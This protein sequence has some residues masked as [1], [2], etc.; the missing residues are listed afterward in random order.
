MKKTLLFAGVLA[1]GI[2]FGQDISLLNSSEN[3]LVLSHELVPVSFETTDING[4]QAINF[5]ESHKITSME[6][7]APEIPFFT[8]S[9]HLP[10]KGKVILSVEHD[11]F[12]EIQN[13][14]VTPSKG[15][16]K[17]N[18][19]PS[20]VAFTFGE[21]YQTDAF[22]PG[23][24][25]E[26][27]EPY[28]F[29]TERGVTVQFNPYQY[30]PVTKTL[31]IYQNLRAVVSID[32]KQE[33]WNEIA[34]DQKATKKFNDYYSHH[35]INFS[36]P[37]Y[38]PVEEEGHMLIITDASYV[39]RFAPFVAWKKEKGIPT[40]VVTTT[41]TGTSDT[42]IKN[43][44]QNFYAD[45][46]ELTYVL[47]GG[48][49]DKVNS[50]TYGLSG[51]EQLWSDSYYGQ[52][53]G[54]SNDYYP[55]VFVG[56]FSGNASQIELMIDRTLEYEKTPAS[57]DWMTRAIGIASSEGA[58]YGNDGQSDWQH[59]RENRQK[60]LD[61][62]YTQV[63]EFYQGSQGGED[64]PGE[65]LNSD[66][67]TAVSNGVGL[68]NYTGHGAQNVCVTGNFSSYDINS[69][70]NEG[71]YPFVISVAC[72][73]GTFT[74]GTCISEVWQRAKMPSGEPTGAI[75]A[76]GSS[77][78]MAWAPPMET[79]DEMTNIITEQYANNKK[80]TLG[81]L[82]YNS[83]I[84][85]MEDYNNNASS[86][87]VMQTWI[88]FGDPSTVYRNKVSQN[89]TASHVDNISQSETA[90]Y[91]SCNVEGATVVLTQLGVEINRA[92]VQ[93]GT[94]AFYFSPFQSTDHLV[95]TATKQ[96]YIPYQGIVTI[97][98]QPASLDEQ[99]LEKVDIYPN[100]T[101]DVLNVRL[102]GANVSAISIVDLS[103]KVVSYTTE[104]SQLNQIDVQGLNSGMY[105]VQMTSTEGNIS[106]KK[107][108]IK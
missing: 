99:L 105:M 95:V 8:E 52:L 58:G 15:N 34:V 55:E 17:R 22:Y 36:Q 18:V 23:N 41:T 70:T 81:G 56:R 82:F 32:N 5:G 13:V 93:N 74:S 14:E 53:A 11:G 49:H 63:Y 75:A 77:I 26:H 84:G 108:T 88:F 91:V 6:L 86:K 97:N 59:A 3:S 65:P 19:N 35:F 76:C 2:T 47:L 57:G 107:I 48:D 10:N 54:G 12:E 33:G 28:I 62:G 7:G 50:H 94:A 39:E 20:D 38:T 64:A 66:I 72:N 67:R 98:G 85:M 24:L 80:E 43:Y 90:L 9:I 71:K 96:N 46:P 51:N 21:E 44:I 31:R 103:G 92:T 101:S 87:E 45:H 30:N 79:Q 16:L 40:T 78:L 83:Q 61:Y 27:S 60:F 1:S 68:M 89:L 37:K 4:T 106:T 102:N 104:I 25:I 69:A 42:H 100:P 73:N 29:R